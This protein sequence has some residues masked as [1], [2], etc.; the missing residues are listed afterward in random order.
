[1]RVR[2]QERSFEEAHL[3]NPAFCGA[4]VY[5]F[6]KS[7]CTTSGRPDIDTPLL[8]IALPIVLHKST[9]RKLPSTVRTSIYTWLQR[10]PEVLVGFANRARD[11]VPSAREALLFSLARE[12]I[13]ISEKGKIS[14][15][16]EKA[17]FTPKFL[18]NSTP[19]LREIV[20]ANRL[21]GRHFAGAGTT[22]T[23]MSAWR[24]RV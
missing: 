5:E 19:E 1:M 22:S 8:F 2:W 16:T 6:V 17:S 13:L 7:F 23:L 18:E 15:G 14:L 4:L 3:F 12:T 21:V 11:F 9:R 24:V 20:A 10:H